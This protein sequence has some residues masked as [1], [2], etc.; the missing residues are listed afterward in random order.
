MTVLHVHHV[1]EHRPDGFSLS[2]HRDAGRGRDGCGL[3]RRRSSLAPRGALKFLTGEVAADPQARKRLVNEAQAASR[4]NHPN[5]A[6]VFEVHEGGETP[7]IAMELVSGQ[8]LKDVLLRGP[9]PPSQ[10]LEVARQIAEGLHEAHQAGV[11]HHDVKPGNVVLDSRGRV[12]VLDFG[13]AVF[14]GRERESEET[15]E[16]FITRT[17]TT[18]S[19]GGTAPYMSPELLRGSPTDA[20][21][22]IFSFGVVLFECLTGRRPFR[23][24][25]PIDT[26][27]A[28]LHQPTPSLR[29][30]FP[31]LAP[32]WE[33]LVERCLAKSPEHRFRTMT[34]VLEGLRRIA[35]DAA[36]QAEKSLAVL[37]FENPGG[38]KEDEY[39]RD[40]ITEDIITELSNLKELRVFSR[41]AVLA[42]RDKSVTAP[43]VGRELNAAYVMEGSLRRAGNHLR[44][45]AQLVDAH[46]GH[47]V[48]A[49]R[50][51]RQLEDIFAIQDEIAQSI[52]Q[53]L[54]LVL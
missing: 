19:A 40:G 47:S 10:V 53:A 4:L 28:I 2:H 42:Y 35:E 21:S 41:S 46:T 24:E 17:A 27:H 16:V 25:T 38:A 3:S 15:E 48:W 33:P 49:K 44:L 9:M 7:F 23:G 29:S 1:S 52:A 20:R 12:K 39:F 32:A 31:E 26:M 34:E 51:D 13:L 14:T 45:T 36:P 18:L 8:S 37:Y 5:I 43:Q 22:D 11:L 30:I 50:F 6:T 54:Q